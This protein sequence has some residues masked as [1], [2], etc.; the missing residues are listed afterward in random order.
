MYLSASTRQFFKRPDLFGV[1]FNTVK[2]TA[3][4]DKA[5]KAGC[6]F[7][8]DNGIFSNLWTEREWLINLIFLYW[9]YRQNCLGVIIPDFL[10]YLGKNQVRGDWQKTL[11]RFYLYHNAVKRLGFKIA[12]ATQDGQ[13]VDLVP[14]ND[15]DVLFI[16]GSNEHKRGKEAEVLALE[17][18]SR[19]K[20]V[21]VGRVSSVGSMKKYWG[22]ADSWDGTTFKFEPDSRE[23]KY[24]PEM[25]KY[26]NLDERPFQ[27]KLC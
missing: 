14:W 8:V 25:D 4:R 6:K 3:K 17:A 15:I 11:E 2:S 10:H 18:K 19:S 7:M 23:E 22:W 21:H 24:I 9:P 16:G 13:P 5:L 26:F 20:W 12:F 27:Y 1:M